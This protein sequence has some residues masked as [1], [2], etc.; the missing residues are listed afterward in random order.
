MLKEHV[1]EVD[2]NNIVI[3]KYEQEKAAIVK[4]DFS[5]Y[6]G[7][8]TELRAAQMR[9]LDMLIVFDR[10]CKKHDIEYFI[11]GGTC[12]GAVRHGGFI[13][14]DDD[15][16]IDVMYKDYPK[17][18]KA[19]MEELPDTY[20]L[21]TPKSEKGYYHMFSRIVDL[22]S[23]MYYPEKYKARQN[24]KNHGL[25]LDIFPLQGGINL[26]VKREVDKRFV[27]LFRFSRGI[28]GSFAKRLFSR[29]VWPL[30]KLFVDF[31]NYVSSTVLVRFSDK[32]NLSH[33]YGTNIV[34]KIRYSNVFPTKP[35]QFEGVW[36]RGPAKPHE[37]LTDLYGDYM[38]IPSPEK[39]ETH[40]V[41]IELF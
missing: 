11:S 16:D 41:K 15:L 8:G 3:R 2:R 9:L 4:E 35:M 34:P 40:S 14:W 39:R 28:G 25:F 1:C 12:L 10:I 21:Q 19:L 7:E 6:N 22:N 26:K 24:L 33:I 5:K 27:T 29:A 13:P 36:F 38:K 18:N 30:S 17:L 31:L 32:E 37:Y 23:R 20:F